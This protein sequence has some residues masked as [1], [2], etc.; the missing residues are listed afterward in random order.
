M[1]FTMNYGVEL[2][3]NLSKKYPKIEGYVFFY[4]LDFLLHW[5]K[6]AWHSVKKEKIK[7]Q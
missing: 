7:R 3:T 4:L 5:L 6:L 2:C 1:P